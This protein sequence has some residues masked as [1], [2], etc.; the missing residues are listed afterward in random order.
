ML[1]VTHAIDTRYTYAVFYGC[2]PKLR[3]KIIDRIDAVEAFHPM[4]LPTIFAD[5]ERDRHISHVRSLHGQLITKSW[6]IPD[7]PS[8]TSSAE[9]DAEMR[10]LVEYST[11]EEV[12]QLWTDMRQLKNGLQDWQVQLTAMID[13]F[14]TQCLTE[15]EAVDISDDS[16]SSDSP[17]TPTT[18][19]NTY[20]VVPEDLNFRIK[21][22]DS[23]KLGLRIRRRLSELHVEYSA[24]VRKCT[25]TLE[26]TSLASQIVSL[27][28]PEI[29]QQELPSLWKQK[30]RSSG[31][32]CP[33][34][35]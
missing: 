7:M 18:P 31:R 4:V 2:S 24:E 28:M 8:S 15:L 12:L 32:L 20:L 9:K 21:R 14:D 34:V 1:S 22:E 6:N 33:N 17:T 26:V 5:I 25:A 29:L 23:R 13:H 16:E 30:S 35:G 11:S 3:T 27:S 19:T 10:E